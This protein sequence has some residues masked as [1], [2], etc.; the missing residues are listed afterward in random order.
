MDSHKD[1]RQRT[2]SS[3]VCVGVCQFY[4]RLDSGERPEN[5]T[6]MHLTHTQVLENCLVL[7]LALSEASPHL[8]P[9]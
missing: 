7:H 4:K 5:A 9:P 8:S 6:V 3:A 2:T 1:F